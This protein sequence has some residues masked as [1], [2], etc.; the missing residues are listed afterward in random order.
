MIRT[1]WRCG[2]CRAR[3]SGF[4]RASQTILIATMAALL[5]VGGCVS[6]KFQVVDASSGK[7]LMGVR[8]NRSETRYYL[9]VAPQSGET[10]LAD[11]GPDGIVESTAPQ[12]VMPEENR[13]SYEFSKR[14][15]ELALLRVDGEHAW[16]I[17]PFRRQDW[18]GGDEGPAAHES[19]PTVE[20]Q[21]KKDVPIRVPLW[22]E[23]PERSAPIPTS[24]PGR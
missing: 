21:V 12:R 5:A 22:P 17:S 24:I 23:P 2:A 6:S 8:V 10:Q 7:P 13:Y 20:M 18:I 1:G 14:G 19:A 4:A 9:G 11:S 16:L 3:W 15:Y